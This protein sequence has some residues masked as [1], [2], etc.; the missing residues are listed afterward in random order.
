[1]CDL[2]VCFILEI[3]FLLFFVFFVLL[4]FGVG[5]GWGGGGGGGGGGGLVFVEVGHGG[6]PLGHE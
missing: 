6:E 4:R 2:G 3:G 5:G 1:M